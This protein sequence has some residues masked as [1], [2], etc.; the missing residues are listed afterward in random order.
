MSLAGGLAEFERYLVDERAASPHTRKVYLDDVGRFLAFLERFAGRNASEIETG[1]VDVLA[2]RSWLASL[3]ADGLARTSIVRRLSALRSFFGFLE[4]EGLAEGNP[5]RGVATPRTDKP[6]PVTLSVAEAAAV[7]EAPPAGTDLGL[8]DRALLELLYG[9]GLRVSELVGLS[10]THVD[11][12]GRQVRTMGKGRKERIVPFGEKA[13]EVFGAWLPARLSLLKGRRVRGEPLFLNVRG[14]RLTDRSVRIIL[15]PRTRPRRHLPSRLAARPAALLRH[16]PPRR[17]GR[18]ADDPGAPRAC[19]ARDDPAVHPPRRRAADGGLRESNRR[20]KK[21]KEAE[22]P[23]EAFLTW[24]ERPGPAALTAEK[25]RISPD[26]RLPLRDQARPEETVNRITGAKPAPAGLSPTTKSRIPKQRRSGVEPDRPPVADLLEAGRERRGG[27]TRNGRSSCDLTRPPRRRRRPWT[28]P[29][30][31]A[32][33]SAG[34]AL[35]GSFAEPSTQQELYPERRLSVRPSRR[36][37]PAGRDGP[38]RKSCEHPLVRPR[39]WNPSTRPVF[40]R[41]RSGQPLH[42]AEEVA[43]PGGLEEQAAKAAPSG[44]SW[45]SL[46]EQVLDQAGPPRRV[47]SRRPSSQNGTFRSVASGFSRTRIA[48][49]SCPKAFSAGMRP[50]WTRRI[51]SSYLH[52]FRPP[53]LDTCSSR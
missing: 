28:G 19:L 25:T 50:P 18:P 32:S 27:R 39:G 23:E 35:P 38:E 34:G 45:S 53:S 16:A 15:S 14:S 29:L 36:A 11:L 51:S 37:S 3:R 26:E 21:K 10:L 2:V 9:T 52:A 44:R 40:R 48:E 47:G 20:R 42:R 41:S 6:L 1:D 46:E 49:Q 8:R 22:G 7:V 33:A 43:V 17:R 5:A 12:P 30:F 13:A 31:E 4:R 24:A